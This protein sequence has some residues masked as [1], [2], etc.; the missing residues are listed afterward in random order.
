[1]IVILPALLATSGGIHARQSSPSIA[2]PTVP[3]E[4][5]VTVPNGLGLPGLDGPQGNHG[6]ATALSTA[7]WDGGPVT[8]KPG[9]PG[10][11]AADGSLL[12][13]WP[14]WRG[15]RGQISVRGRNLDGKSGTVRVAYVPYGETGFQAS[16]LVFPAPGCWEVTGQVADRTLSFVVAVEKIEAGPSSACEVLFPAAALRAL[17]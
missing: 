16:A 6:D 7:L 10:C 5:P 11:V 14:W 15:V 9:G 8:F 12:M 2:A 4:C 3:A 17:K 1:L 13:K